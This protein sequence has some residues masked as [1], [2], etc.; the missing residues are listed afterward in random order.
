MFGTKTSKRD[1][2]LCMVFSAMAVLWTRFPPITNPSFYDFQSLLDLEAIKG[3]AMEEQ[4]WSANYTSRVAN[5]YMRF[6]YV[7]LFHDTVGVPS[8]DVDVIWHLHILDTVKY[9]KDCHTVFQRPFLHHRPSY[10]VDD[11]AALIKPANKFMQKY[12]DVFGPFPS[13]IWFGGE[14]S[15]QNCYTKQC[16]ACVPQDCYSQEFA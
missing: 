12:E 6:L 2:M 7:T 8:R 13:D 3:K 11:R 1:V 4:S 9:M 10:T 5:E 14:S 16:I 15:P